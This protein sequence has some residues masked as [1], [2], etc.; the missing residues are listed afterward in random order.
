M[1]DQEQNRKAMISGEH[2]AGGDAQFY[3]VN[4]LTRKTQLAG[5]ME[6]A[7]TGSARSKGL[8]GRKSLEPGEALWIVPC[9][10]VHT[11]W[12]QFAIDL[13]YIDK[14]Y[15]V[16]KVCTAVPPWRISGCLSAHSVIELPAGVVQQTETQPGDILEF[17]LSSRQEDSHKPD[18]RS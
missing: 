3:Q 5:H 11:F 10:A 13:V 16:R 6:V 4:N 7:G 14:K 18:S 1:Q 17:V 8:L 15:K 12:M 2:Q 9:E